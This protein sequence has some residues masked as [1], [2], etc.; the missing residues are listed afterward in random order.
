MY[1]PV[2]RAGEAES[3][4]RTDDEPVALEEGAGELKLHGAAGRDFVA[5]AEG[6]CVASPR[7]GGAAV[8][9]HVAKEKHRAGVQHDVV[10][11]R[12]TGVVADLGG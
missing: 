4:R 11:G 12:G 8:C 10:I 2:R 6:A 3:A 7:A 1:G 5:R 9:A